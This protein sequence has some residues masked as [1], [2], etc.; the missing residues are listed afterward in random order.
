MIGQCVTR[1]IPY[2]IP[3]VFTAIFLANSSFDAA[4]ISK[5]RKPALQHHH[6]SLTILKLHDFRK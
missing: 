4:L 1:R 5:S 2:L 6:S 3:D